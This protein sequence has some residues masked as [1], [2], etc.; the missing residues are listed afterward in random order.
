MQREYLE[1]ASGS[2]LFMYNRSPL[3]TPPTSHTHT[4]LR[5]PLVKTNITVEDLVVAVH[6]VLANFIL[7]IPPSQ[8]L[9]LYFLYCREPGCSYAP[10]R[11]QPWLLLSVTFVKCRAWPGTCRNSKV[12]V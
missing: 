10:W 6:S 12:F 8:P 5:R 1:R 9:S 11:Q 7:S 2:L 3:P 4:L